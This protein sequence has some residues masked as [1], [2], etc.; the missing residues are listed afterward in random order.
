MFA[1][2]P[3]VIAIGLIAILAFVMM[4]NTGSIFVEKSASIKASNIVKEMGE[5][6]SATKVYRALE[7]KMPASLSDLTANGKYLS[8][9]PSLAYAI[10]TST[11]EVSF[12][13]GSP[14][15]DEIPGDVCIEI[16]K[17]ATGDNTLT[18]VPADATG[19]A[20]QEYG[21]YGNPSVGDPLAVFHK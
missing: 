15:S 12:T 21:C 1:I 5:V 16:Q 2:V 4:D 11:A 7:S 20:G 9:S 18:T 13:A 17:M 6:R 10:D 8:S 19:T 3:I 14:T